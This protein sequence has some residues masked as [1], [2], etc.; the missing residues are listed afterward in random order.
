MA[1]FRVFRG[2]PSDLSLVPL[3]DGYSYVCF[4]DDSNTA[5]FYTDVPDGSGGV[6]RVQIGGGGGANVTSASATLAAAS[7]SNG[8][9]TVSVTGVTANSNGVIGLAETA[10]SAQYNA[11]LEAGLM[12]TAQG[13]GTITV[14][15]MGDASPTVDIP[16][17]ILLFD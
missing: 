17:V 5:T 9:Q 16:V 13:S 8:A 15:V 7:W 1:L 10:T 11:A 4:T 3:H 14:S 12:L 6:K 2:D